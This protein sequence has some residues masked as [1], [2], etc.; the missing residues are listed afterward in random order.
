MFFKEGQYIGKLTGL[1][2]EETLLEKIAE[3]V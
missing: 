3:M 2:E 1:V